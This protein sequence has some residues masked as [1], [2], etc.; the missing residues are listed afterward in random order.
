[1][2]LI[3]PI[4]FFPE[5]V[6]PLLGFV[7]FLHS[8][9]LKQ[10]LSWQDASGCYGQEQHPKSNEN[11][12]KELQETLLGADR[13]VV[14]GFGIAPHGPEVALPPPDGVVKAGGFRKPPVGNI[15]LENIGPQG[16]VPQQWAGVPPQERKEPVQAGGLAAQGAR[17]PAWKGGLP[18]SPLQAGL[19]NVV[20][21][22]K[23][24]S[25]NT[26]VL[27]E[28]NSSAAGAQ[29]KQPLQENKG[30][31]VL[32]D[33]RLQ[34]TGDKVL[35][36][37]VNDLYMQN[38]NKKLPVEQLQRAPLLPMPPQRSVMK[39]QLNAAL[40]APAAGIGN[41]QMVPPL[42]QQWW[43]QRENNQY[44]QNQA[45]KQRRLLFEKKMPGMCYFHMLHAV[46]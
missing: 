17:V 28:G 38:V 23:S 27:R 7:E 40:A 6:C 39:Q 1:M 10:I 42:N 43:Q 18:Y 25:H 11:M 5:F 14:P 32:N 46:D 3:L 44:V 22:Q 13:G 29:H 2:H 16:G 19:G 12:K 36:R 35:P 26:L 8:D 37:S 24:G 33:H 15:H 34:L 45:V 31:I 9:W 41:K 21:Q 4:A 20:M 30:S